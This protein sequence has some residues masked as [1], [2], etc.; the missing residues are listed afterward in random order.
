MKRPPILADLFLSFEVTRFFDTEKSYQKKVIRVQDRLREA[1]KFVLDRD[2]IR[3]VGEVCRDAPEAI[4]Y[5][6][7]FALPPFP[8]MWVEFDS[9]ELWRTVNVGVDQP[10]GGWGDRLVGFLIDG[11]KV[12]TV[13]GSDPEHW[14]GNWASL[15]PIIYHLNQPGISDVVPEGKGFAHAHVWADIGIDQLFWGSAF[16]RMGDDPQLQR[17]L[18]ANHSATMI[19]AL[20]NDEARSQFLTGCMGDLRTVLAILLTLNRSKDIQ[21]VEQPMKTG[22]L[23]HRKPVSLVKHRVIKIN[24]SPTKDI[25][26]LGKRAGSSW[27][28]RFDVR[29]HFCR[30]KQARLAENPWGVCKD[31]TH[32]WQET[33]ARGDRQWGCLKC[34][35]LKW[36]RS[37]H[38]KGNEFAGTVNSSYEVTA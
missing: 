34:G 35:G 23:L 10:H 32:D 8:L 24:L 7:E 37:E 28:R 3:F 26:R 30:N 16:N 19:R 20:Y 14:G 18:R 11:P 27:R 9:Q 6:Q 25:I 13:A 2:A 21:Y 5:A 33:G 22:V 15:T 12:Y 31:V 17:S 29:G 4:A 1:K 36:W 38:Q